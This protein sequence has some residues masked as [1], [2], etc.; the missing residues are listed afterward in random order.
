MR[1]AHATLHCP[2]RD[3]QNLGGLLGSKALLKDELE[4]SAM[5]RRETVQRLV[6]GKAAEHSIFW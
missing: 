2:E 6:E 3:I 1:V 4:H 5:L